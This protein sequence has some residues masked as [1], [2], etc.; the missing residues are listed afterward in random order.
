MSATTPIPETA[1]PAGET[2]AGSCPYC[3]RPFATERQRDLHI[4]EQHPAVASDDER[5]AAEAANE[6]E[7][8]ELFFYHMKV[9]VAIG[10]LYSALVIVYMVV[11]GG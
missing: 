10:L 8:D 7:V 9:I 1:V 2:P 3:D 5:A 11:L 4:V 6:A